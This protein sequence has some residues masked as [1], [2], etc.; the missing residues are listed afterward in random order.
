MLSGSLDLGGKLLAVSTQPA[1]VGRFDL[2]EAEVFDFQV[3]SVLFF[4][5][6]KVSLDPALPFFVSEI[7]QGDGVQVDISLDKALGKLVFW[8]SGG[9]RPDFRTMNRFRGQ[10]MKEVIEAVFASVLGLLIAGDYLKLENNFVDET[11]VE[12]NANQHKVVWAKSRKKYDERLRQK[13]KEILE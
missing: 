5:L 7:D 2:L 13:V 6:L 3:F 1:S 12:A 8:I 10:V 4:H 11:K 9:N